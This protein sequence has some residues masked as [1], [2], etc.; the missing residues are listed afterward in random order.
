[1]P[2]K[3]DHQ[4]D[5]FVRIVGRLELGQTTRVQLGE[6][7]AHVTVETQQPAAVLLILTQMIGQLLNGQLCTANPRMLGQIRQIAEDGI[8]IT[9]PIAAG[10]DLP[11]LAF[12]LILLLAYALQLFAQSL[13]LGMYSAQLGIQLSQGAPA[14]PQRLLALTRAL[15][16]GGELIEGFQVA[17][18]LLVVMLSLKLQRLSRPNLLGSS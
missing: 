4:A 2:A 13:H 1:M 17:Q 5:L 11:V 18:G 10:T 16:Q 15:A 6:Q 9:A 12:E 3:L 14:V 7:A 8:A